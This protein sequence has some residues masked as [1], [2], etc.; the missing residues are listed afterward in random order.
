MKKK[1][2]G[3]IGV[4]ILSYC[5]VFA[6]TDTLV[7]YYPFNGNA[8]DSSGNGFNG[9][10][11]GQI[12]VTGQCGGAYK[13]T[14]TFITCGDPAGNEFDLVNNASISLW[15]KLYSFPA[16]VPSSGLN[17]GYFILIGKDVGPGDNDK[18]FLATYRGHLVIHI[19][20]QSQVNGNWAVQ[21]IFPFA[22]NTFYHIVVT[23]T[24]YTYKF[25]VNGVFYGFQ[26]IPVNIVD[27]AAPLIIGDLQDGSLSLNAAIDEVMIYHG[28]LTEA[29]INQLYNCSQGPVTAISTI[30][31]D[32]QPDF[33]IYPNPSF[34][35]FVLS[36]ANQ[37]IEVKNVSVFNV[38]GE[39]VFE[40]EFQLYNRD[41]I[42]DLGNKPKGVYL[43][44][45]QTR[46][47][48]MVSKISVQ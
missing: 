34:G 10:L 28:A 33:K 45:L 12:P 41:V 3:I 9:A 29:K 21:T 47:K 19:N 46:K 40:Q 30:I 24:D 8:N 39:K 36:F 2:A 44:Q 35:K 25:Y 7:A 20:D 6:Q 18:W 13:F 14:G 48:I 27:V 42:I 26:T 5:H 23:K 11:N 4:L 31:Q 16:N 43:L 1:Y 32:Q 15:M 22:L 37:M 17:S 38:L